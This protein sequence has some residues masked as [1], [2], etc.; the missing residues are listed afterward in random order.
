MKINHKILNYSISFLSFQTMSNQNISSF[1][2]DTENALLIQATVESSQKK[3]NSTFTKLILAGV[4]S[5]VILAT[6][7]IYH[8]TNSKDLSASSTDLNSLFNGGDYSRE[9][10]NN[11][12]MKIFI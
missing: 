5:F 6:F 11:A 1:Q 8:P 2:S 12:S 3:S 9:T 7:A 10:H 4:V